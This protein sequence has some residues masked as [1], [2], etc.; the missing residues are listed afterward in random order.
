VVE[1]ARA[2]RRCGVSAQRPTSSAQES[3]SGSGSLGKRRRRGITSRDAGI[4]CRRRPLSTSLAVDPYLWRPSCRNSLTTPCAN[5]TSST[6]GRRD[7]GQGRGGDASCHGIAARQRLEQG[8]DRS[9]HGVADPGPG[10]RAVGFG[11]RVHHA[12]AA[13]G[14]GSGPLVGLVI[15]RLL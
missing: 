10:D 2:L 4:R 14:T 12:A 8:R 7:G 13:E 11:D 15:G 1:A 6:G 9:Q 5:P 3:G